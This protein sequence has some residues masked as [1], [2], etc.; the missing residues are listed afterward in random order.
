MHESKGP[1]PPRKKKLKFIK[2]ESH[3]KITCT[4]TRAPDLNLTI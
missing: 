1:P 4:K 2:F 3:S